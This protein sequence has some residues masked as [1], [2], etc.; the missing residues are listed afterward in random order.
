M[1]RQAARFVMNSFST[2]AIELTQML[3]NL[4]W[5]TLAECMTRESYNDKIIHNSSQFLLDIYPYPRHMICAI[6]A[7]I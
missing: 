3:T 2:Y 1:Q 6:E 5:L 7:K 4:N